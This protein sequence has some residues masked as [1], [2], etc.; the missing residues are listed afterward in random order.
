MQ[1]SHELRYSTPTASVIASL[2]GP[3]CDVRSRVWLQALSR[4]RL[5]GAT[6]PERLQEWE[7]KMPTVSWGVVGY[8]ELVGLSL[9]GVRTGAWGALPGKL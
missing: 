6:E 9:S 7:H 8:V 5:T 3:T 4:L 1:S 2:V